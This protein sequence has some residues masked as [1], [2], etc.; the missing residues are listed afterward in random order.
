LDQT[1]SRR[2]GG[3]AGAGRA[4]EKLKTIGKQSVSIDLIGDRRFWHGA[5]N[6]PVKSTPP[7]E[8][9]RSMTEPDPN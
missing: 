4:A 6:I 5:C 9:D 3:L 7:A 1:F 8:R 2:W